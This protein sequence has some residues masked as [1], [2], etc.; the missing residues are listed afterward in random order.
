MKINRGKTKYGPTGLYSTFSFGNLD[1]PQTVQSTLASTANEALCQKSWSSYRTAE[2]MLNRC[3]DEHN[4]VLTL[5]LSERL[6]ALFVGWLINKELSVSTIRTYLSGVR[7]L[8]LTKGFTPPNLRSPVIQHILTGKE[9]S[10]NR[11]KINGNKKVRL[12]MT[13][14]LLRILKKELINSSLTGQDKACFWS[15]STLAFSGGFRISELLCKDQNSFDPDYTCLKKDIMLKSPSS[16]KES[17]QITLRSDKTN[18]S[19]LSVVIDI[20]GS[21]SDICP[22]RAF[23]KYSSFTGNNADTQ[24][25]FK[26]SSGSALTAKK[27]NS[28][29]KNH[30]TPHIGNVNGFLSTHSFRIGITSLL[31]QSGLPT[32]ELKQI[33]RWSSSSYEFYLKLP[34]TNRLRLAEKISSML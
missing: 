20:F 25:A 16:G 17:L 4:E 27:L 15:V 3:L 10:E 19:H 34:R 23:K 2:K 26:L 31:G 9:N 8:H 1:L 12:P 29:I 14:D 22:I 7:T 5:P 28:F 24:P 6:T 11:E 30:L 32:E 13:P 18:R 33:G 21:G